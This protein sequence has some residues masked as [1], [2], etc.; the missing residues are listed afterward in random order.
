MMNKDSSKHEELNLLKQCVSEIR[1]SLFNIDEILPD[2]IDENFANQFYDELVFFKSLNKLILPNSKSIREFPSISNSLKSN[3]NSIE[4]LKE[5]LINKNN[6]NDKELWKEEL[7][8]QVAPS[9]GLRSI[10]IK[11]LLNTWTEDQKKYNYLIFWAESLNKYLPDDFPYGLQILN[12]NNILKSGFIYLLVPIIQ[13]NSIYK[14]RVYTRSSLSSISNTTEDEMMYDIRFQV[15]RPNE[16]SQTK[17]ICS[18]DPEFS[19]SIAINNEIKTNQNN[20]QILKN[21]EQAEPSYLSSVSNSFNW[22]TSLVYHSNTVPNDKYYNL[23]STNVT[24]I[25]TPTK[26]DKI[27]P[28]PSN[29]TP[30]HPI[31][32]NCRSDNNN[33][34][35][36]NTPPV[37]I[38]H[39]IRDNTREINSSNILHPVRDNCRK[40]QE[41]IQSISI[42]QTQANSNPQIQIDISKSLSPDRKSVNA[43][44]TDELS[45]ADRINARLAKLRKP[46]QQNQSN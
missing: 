7:E 23:S 8:N 13:K 11:H 5:K 24:S 34:S 20:N 36:T 28:G 46:I 37:I 9:F 43:T 39:P 45:P 22:M 19:L 14:I 41:D 32:N 25:I 1:K 2:T 18:N 38:N 35:P 30:F 27:T 4:I 17:Y 33:I 21:I 44:V 6:Q 31:K 26:T 40:P 12:V 29:I 16:N 15:F 42:L 3:V 10:E